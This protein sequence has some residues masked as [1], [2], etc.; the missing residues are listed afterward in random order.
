MA[1]TGL[2]GGRVPAVTAL[3]CGA[4]LAAYAVEPLGRSLIYDRAAIEAGELWRLVSGSLAHHSPHH[5]LWNVAAM[6]V[7][8]TLVERLG[9]RHF[10]AL[11][12]AAA[13]AVGVAIYLAAPELDTFAG[14]SG[15]AVAAVVFLCLDGLGDSGPWRWICLAA[16]AVTSL[17]IG[18]E[19]G[20]G[21]SL[22]GSLSTEGFVLAPVSHAAGALAAVLVAVAVRGGRSR[23]ASAADRA[24]AEPAHRHP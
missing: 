4:A 14:L 21:G 5:L 11:C 8:G 16:L 23:G 24:A 10:A 13:T 1:A 19:L 18:L 2:S 7:A 3:V 20:T 9:I 17:K 22:L 12:L 15:V 6:A